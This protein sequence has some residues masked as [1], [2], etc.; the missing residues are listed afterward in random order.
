MKRAIREWEDRSKEIL[1]LRIFWLFGLAFFLTGVI[2][3]H[4]GRNWIGTA[5]LI[6][7]IVEMIWW[8][9]PPFRLVGSPLEFD[10]LLNNKL[11]FTLVTLVFILTTWHIS[12][13]K[14]KK[15]PQLTVG[16]DRKPPPQP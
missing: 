9:S 4:T 13:R 16:G 6:P 8:T 10:R 15:D 2:M 11:G 5:F 12:Q 1:E 14:A 7:G 3:S